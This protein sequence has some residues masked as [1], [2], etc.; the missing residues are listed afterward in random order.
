MWDTLVR[1]P[2]NFIML[3]YHT[4]G[5]IVGKSALPKERDCVYPVV[6]LGR[7]GNVNVFILG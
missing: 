7:E 5:V 2:L 6:I 4:T 1:I 3:P